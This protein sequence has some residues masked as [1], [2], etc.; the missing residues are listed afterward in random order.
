[1]DE[2]IWRGIKC[3]IDSPIISHLFFA[4]DLILFSEASTDQVDVMASCL[5]EFCD[6]SSQQISRQKSRLRV[7][8][9][10]SGALARSSSHNS[11]LSHASKNTWGCLSSM[12]ELIKVLL[13]TSLRRWKIN[14]LGGKPH[15]YP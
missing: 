15:A 1:M 10:V 12:V 5:A 14:F 3:S 13:P 11:L 8:K 9:N 2:G 6:M 7:S 4:D